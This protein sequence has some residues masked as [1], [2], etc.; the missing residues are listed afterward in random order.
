MTA[1]TP[2]PISEIICSRTGCT[3]TAT[4]GMLWNNP[5]LHTPERRKVWLTCDEHRDYFRSYLSSRSFLKQEVAVADLERKQ[6]D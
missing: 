5:K 6:D 1:A 4:W 2:D 3:T